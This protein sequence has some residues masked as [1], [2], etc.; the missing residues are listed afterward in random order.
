MKLFS[1]TIF[2]LSICMFHACTQDEACRENTVA[3]LRAGFHASETT[4]S[5][6]IDSITVV[7]LQNDTLVN[8]KKNSSKIALPLNNAEEESI[9]VLNINGVHDTLH[10]Y[11]TNADYFISYA[12]GMT[13]AHKI[14]T[15]TATNHVIKSLKII[16]KD[17]N[18][19][20]VPH[21]QILL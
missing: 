5:L 10:V 16:H 14:D 8:N 21:V 20:D 3:L 11:Y 7:G 2:L 9:F 12:C 4:K 6:T 18:T 17:I 15:I 19:T 13:V 1:L